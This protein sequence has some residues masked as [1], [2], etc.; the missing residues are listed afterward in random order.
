MGK[1]KKSKK[2][3]L[4]G[5]NPEAQRLKDFKPVKMQDRRAPKG[6]STNKKRILEDYD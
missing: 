5:R 3:P 6:G 2:K 1:T 4:N